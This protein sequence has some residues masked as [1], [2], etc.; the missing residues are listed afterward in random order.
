MQATVE[1]IWTKTTKQIRTLLNTETYNLWFSSVQ[2]VSLNQSSITLEVPNEFSEVWLKDNYLEL[3]QDALAQASGRKLNIK[4]KVA[5]GGNGAATAPAKPTK[6]RRPA[7]RKATDGDL[8]FNP[9]NTFET[10]VVGNNNSFAHAAAMAVAQQPGK[11]Y[12]PLFL[13]GGTGL[14]KTHLLHAIGQHVVGSKKAAKVSY[15]S[16][17]K[18]TNEYIAAIQENQLVK[19]RKKYRQ[20]DVL[21]IDDIQFL[22]GKERIQEEFFHTFNAL[23]E[24]HKQLVL[25]CDRPASEIQNLEHR[26]VSRFEWG[27]VTDLQPPDVETR[28]AILRN[29]VKS[30]G[31]EIPEDVLT[32]LANRI[33]TN[34]R[35][36]EGA[37]IRVASYA[38][39]TGKELTHDVVENLLREIL[40][41]EGRHTITMEVI[42][43]KVVEKFDL[44]MADMTSK[45]RPENIAFPRQIAMYLSRQLTEHSLSAIGEAF[46]GRDHGTVLHAC[47]LVK[48]RMEIDANVRQTVHYLEKQLLR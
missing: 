41:E 8:M 40:Q 37:L 42:Q 4:F 13:Y 30:M 47:R 19:F 28:L 18:F 1:K 11:A 2:P 10:F 29:K 15:V 34:I 36:L 23:H 12:N 3:L 44:R 9:R 27:L 46:G 33:R 7:A 14:G 24:A 43:K 22:A 48:D 45:R 6:G 16:S 17:E 21:L 32:F 35:R 25:T 31:V 39:L 38:H 26:L 20:T 5:V